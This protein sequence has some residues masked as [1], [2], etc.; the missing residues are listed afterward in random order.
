MPEAAQFR[1]G[2]RCANDR[3]RLRAGQGEP[4][5]ITDLAREDRASNA[6]GESEPYRMGQV[7]D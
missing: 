7:V 3:P 1:A 6:A 2:K 4:E 5:E